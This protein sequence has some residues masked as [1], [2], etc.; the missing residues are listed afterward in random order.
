VCRKALLLSF[1]PPPVPRVL[2]TAGGQTSAGSSLFVPDNTFVH[3]SIENPAAAGGGVI[4]P[5]AGAASL[6]VSKACAAPEKLLAGIVKKRVCA[7]CKNEGHQKNSKQCPMRKQ[8]S[9]EL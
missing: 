5:A 2:T 9:L 1:S 7:A 6:P 8:D 3:S 4:P